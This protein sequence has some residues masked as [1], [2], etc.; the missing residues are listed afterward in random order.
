MYQ[1]ITIGDPV[2]DTHVQ[3]ASDQ[4]SVQINEHDDQFLCFP[5]GEKI[6]II[7]SF[8]SLGGNAANVAASAQL[9]GVKSA[10]ITT[11][12][13]DSAA[14]LVVKK[15]QENGISTEYVSIDP[16]SATRYSLVLNYE[17]ERT[18]LSHSEKRN[19]NWPDSVSGTD[20]VYYTG[21]GEGFEAVQKK[22]LTYLKTH[23]STRLAVNPGSYM[24]K[25]G[26]KAFREILAVTDLLLVNLE[27]AEVLADTTLKR[28]KNLTSLTHALLALGPN[29][30]VITDGEHGAFA[31]TQESFW[32]VKAPKVKVVSKTGA[33]DAFSAGYL[34]AR[35]HKHD[36]PHALAW[37]IANSAGVIQEHGAQAGLQDQK[38]IEK[39]LKKHAI[40]AVQL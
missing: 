31:G 17:T 22:L 32:E 25:H 9:L 29:E 16:K 34:A 24:L 15:L 33:G 35:V 1:L 10:I 26:M 11:L 7:N 13:D 14:E 21:L 30:V 37:G 3:L 8:Q 18:I 38:G 2:I 28:E 23:Q 39:L 12:G 19:Y 20:W 6:S 27:E 40:Q 36:I 5:Y 4:A